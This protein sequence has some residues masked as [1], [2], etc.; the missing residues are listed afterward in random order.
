MKTEYREQIDVKFKRKIETLVRKSAGSQLKTEDSSQIDT[1]H[2]SCPYCDNEVIDTELLCHNCRNTIPFC[3][4]T[5]LH[6]VAN[7]L[8]VCPNCQF[9][10][11]LSQL[12]KILANEKTCPMCNTAINTSNIVRLEDV[13]QILDSNDK[14]V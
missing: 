5:G 3:I 13:K 11:I 14:N 2:T 12:L 6:I 9:P 10:A 8:T 4:A 1:T 7:D